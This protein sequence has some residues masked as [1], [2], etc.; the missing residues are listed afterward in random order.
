MGGQYPTSRGFTG[1]FERKT[2]TGVI[3]RGV[4]VATRYRPT[5]GFFPELPGGVTNDFPW[6]RPADF[7]SRR[8]FDPQV[9]KQPWDRR[10]LRKGQFWPQTRTKYPPFGKLS[11][12]PVGVQRWPRLPRVPLGW[13]GLLPIAAIPFYWNVGGFNT[14]GL[15]NCFDVGPLQDGHGFLGPTP[16]CFPSLANLGG[17]HMIPG[18]NMTL[19]ANEATLMIGWVQQYGTQPLGGIGTWKAMWYRLTNI[20]KPYVLIPYLI[21]ELVP[22]LPLNPMDWRPLDPQPYNPNFPN[23][24]WGHPSPGAPRPWPGEPWRG[25]RSTPPTGRRWTPRR[26]SQAA[27]RQLHRPHRLGPGF[28]VAGHAVAP[29]PAP[30]EG[31]QPVA[32]AF[33]RGGAVC[34]VCLPS[35][36]VRRWDDFTPNISDTQGVDGK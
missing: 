28:E 14:S 8:E 9:G 2:G 24:V 6:G 36:G 30:L 27:S 1:G 4:T 33:F 22:W 10:G 20:N 3:P 26:R 13:L 12:A 15:I 34:H 18:R 5:S 11:P 31:D 25:R 16:F 21:P 35:R 17:Q 7:P 32:A 29:I 19:P 23:P